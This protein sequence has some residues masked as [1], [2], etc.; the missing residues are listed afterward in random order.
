LFPVEKIKSGINNDV[1]IPEKRPEIKQKVQEPT[2][3]TEVT[4]TLSA[5]ARSNRS[6][7]TYFYI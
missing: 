5:L 2:S 1:R 7:G 4:L 6:N 3:K